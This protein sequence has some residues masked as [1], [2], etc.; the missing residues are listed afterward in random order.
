[1]DDNQ[2]AVVKYSIYDSQNTGVKDLFNLN[3]NTGEISLKKT[4]AQWGELI[5]SFPYVFPHS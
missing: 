2:N 5:F 3:E 4:A 1:M